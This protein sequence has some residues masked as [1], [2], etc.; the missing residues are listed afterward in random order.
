MPLRK[1]KL[2]QSQTVLKPTLK[3]EYKTE[4]ITRQN[5]FAEHLSDIPNSVVERPAGPLQSTPSGLSANRSP[6]PPFFRLYLFSFSRNPSFEYCQAHGTPFHNRVIPVGSEFRA[7]HPPGKIL[8]LTSSQ[9]TSDQ[10]TGRTSVRA[11]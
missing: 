9:Q 5:H 6:V 8:V 7:K 10:G 4:H 11:A 2:S 1:R 3:L